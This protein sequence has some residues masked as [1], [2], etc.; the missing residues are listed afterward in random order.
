MS[1]N[2]LGNEGSNALASSLQFVTTLTLLDCSACGI[3]ASGFVSWSECLCSNRSITWLALNDN[4]CGDEGAVALSN[5]LRE[6][7]DPSLTLLNLDNTRIQEIGATALLDAMRA[8]MGLKRL[9]LRHNPI[10]DDLCKSLVS[11]SKVRRFCKIDQGIFALSFHSTIMRYTLTM[12]VLL[13]SA[14]FV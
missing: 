1:G 5:V 14:G 13:Y 7:P 6:Q 11:A 9:S 10:P 12:P 8:G 4:S 2:P 3:E